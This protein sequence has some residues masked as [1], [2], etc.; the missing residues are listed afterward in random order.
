MLNTSIRKIPGIAA[1]ITMLLLS[2]S[3]NAQKDAQSPF[4]I[5]SDILDNATFI[6]SNIP[7]SLRT[8]QLYSLSVTVRNTG[9]HTWGL[10]EPYRLSLYNAYDNTYQT[11]VWGVRSV[12]LPYAVK[13]DEKVTFIFDV[14][15]PYQSGTYN[16]RWRMTKEGEFFGEATASQLIAVTGDENIVPYSYSSYNSAS[17]INQSV[18]SVMTA[19]MRYKVIVT[20]KNTGSA[21]W[22]PSNSNSALGDYKLASVGES[23][24]TWGVS[25]FYLTRAVRPGITGTFEFEVIAPSAAGYYNFQWQMM[26]GSAYFGEATNPVSVYVANY[27]TEPP[28]PPVIRT[29][30]SAVFVD[31]SVPSSMRTG[32]SYNVSVSFRNTGAGTW[33]KGEH[34]LVYSNYTDPRSMRVTYNPWGIDRVEIPYDASPGSTVTFNFNVTAPSEPGTYHFQWIMTDNNGTF[35]DPSTDVLVTVK[36]RSYY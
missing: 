22:T 21:V 10:D 27:Y 29:Y 11:D 31:Q 26:Q 6:T 35:G 30:N 36:R 9:L 18:P 16:M 23:N 8:G 32:R 1:I 2:P 20:L 25:P 3:V 7:T 4:N 12:A 24:T 33:F 13:R 34:R 17:Y 15:A 14:K 5:I 19:G 28:P